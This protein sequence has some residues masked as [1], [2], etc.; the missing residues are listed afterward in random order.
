MAE[1]KS[2]NKESRQVSDPVNHPTHYTFGKFE[3]IEVPCEDPQTIIWWWN[4]LRGEKEY[5]LFDSVEDAMT[6][7]DKWKVEYPWNT[8]HVATE[9]LTHAATEK[10]KEAHAFTYTEIFIEPQGAP[11]GATPQAE[12]EVS[13]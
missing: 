7:L 13:K 11:A 8:Y 5:E 9:V 1:E 4:Q 6:E 2:E 12:K 10:W 3:V